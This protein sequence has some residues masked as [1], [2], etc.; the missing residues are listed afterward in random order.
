MAEALFELGS[1]VSLVQV[2]KAH[3]TINLCH[4]VLPEFPVYGAIIQYCGCKL[5]NTDGLFV[6]QTLFNT[7]T[8]ND[9]LRKKI[10]E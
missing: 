8:F 1:Q 9:Y 5:Q 2:I 6:R 10:P 4:S 7:T 3:S